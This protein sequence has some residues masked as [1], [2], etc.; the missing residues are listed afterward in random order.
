MPDSPDSDTRQH[1]NVPV[2]GRVRSFEKLV[3]PTRSMAYLGVAR[4]DD[5]FAM[6]K[7]LAEDVSKKAFK[8]LV[9]IRQMDAERE[10]RKYECQ[11]SLV[12]E[13]TLD[14]YTVRPITA[15]HNI[16]NGE[17][18]GVVEQFRMAELRIPKT[19]IQK[20]IELEFPDGGC[21]YADHNECDIARGEQ[22]RN[23]T[24]VLHSSTFQPV[25]PDFQCV[26]G[27]KIAIV[28]YSENGVTPESASVPS[29]Y[30]QDELER[31]Y[32][33]AKQINI[34]TGKITHVGPDRI[35]YD[36]NTFGGCSGAIVFLLDTD[37]PDSVRPEDFGRA[38]A[39]HSGP[40]PSASGNMAFLL[41]ASHI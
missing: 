6:S 15:K 26:I 21:T 36:I 34:L 24:L 37:Q 20:D 7:R 41:S 10:T 33:K 2:V 28:V 17:V 11:V 35:C 9:T 38:I 27:Q 40:H 13:G 3:E 5:P 1:D 22:V 39:V 4:V 23:R 32:G 29:G 18:D 31:I 14:A 16:A 8:L 19:G 12:R 30:S 25:R